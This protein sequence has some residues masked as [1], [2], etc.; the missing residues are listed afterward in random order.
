MK[1]QLLN[2]DINSL[3]TKREKLASQLEEAEKDHQQ[4]ERKAVACSNSSMAAYYRVQELK[5][6][7]EKINEAIMVLNSV[8]RKTI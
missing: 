3:T 1:S 4:K 2:F 5:Q 8:E 6:A 7:I